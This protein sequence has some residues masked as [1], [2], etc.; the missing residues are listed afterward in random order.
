MELEGKSFVLGTCTGLYFCY[1]LIVL[2]LGILKHKIDFRGI[3]GVIPGIPF[4]FRR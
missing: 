2:I 1:C 4:S 3:Y